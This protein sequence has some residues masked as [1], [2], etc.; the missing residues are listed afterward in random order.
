MK[1]NLWLPL[2]FVLSFLYLYPSAHLRLE[3]L[4]DGAASYGAWQ[5]ARGAVPYRDFMIVTTPAHFYVLAFLMKLFG[6]QLIVER[7]WQCLVWSGALVTLYAA[8]NLLL[9][10]V[11]ALGAWVMA[12]AFVGRFPHI[13]GAMPSSLLFALLTV[14]FCL[15]TLPRERRSALFAAG[16]CAGLSALFRQ[17]IGAYT[18][19]AVF[20]TFAFC[21]DPAW[22]RK[23]DLRRFLAGAACVLAPAAAYFLIRVPW[24]TLFSDLVWFPLKTYRAYSHLPYPAF[25]ADIEK[26][27]FFYFTPVSIIL[28]TLFLAAGWQRPKREEERSPLFW[29]ML[30]LSVIGVL[31]LSQ[32]RFRADA[33]HLLPAYLIACL[34][35][36]FLFFCVHQRKRTL[37]LLP[38]ALAVAACLA[39]GVLAKASSLLLKTPPIHLNVPRSERIDAAPR[40]AWETKEFLDYQKT[41]DHVRSITQPGDKVFV[42]SVRHDRVCYADPAFYFLSERDS[43]TSYPEM[44]RGVVTTEAVQREMISELEKNG[45]NV[46]VRRKLLDQQCGEPNE[47]R[48]PSGAKLLDEYLDSHYRLDRR[49]GG[50]EVWRR[51]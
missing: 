43:G 8:A 11:F 51:V 15:R 2:L 35:S 12:L 32:A 18:M 10:A 7:V 23:G 48:N 37:F 44:H 4:D 14:H 39:P 30:L 22:R 6:P 41:V 46:V 34:A 50:N 38:A 42:G 31:F 49:F 20:T 40:D 25:T 3:Y 5:V 45:V 1:K 29:P 21:H 33:V 16:A 9:P 47:S 17:D 36:A 19:L 13:A 26:S 28:T 27:Y 24:G